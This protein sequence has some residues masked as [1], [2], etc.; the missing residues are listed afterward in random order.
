[1]SMDTQVLHVIH[2]VQVLLEMV[3][4]IQKDAVMQVHTVHVIVVSLD[5]HVKNAMMTPHV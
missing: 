2:N 4:V 1:M 3:Y 5:T